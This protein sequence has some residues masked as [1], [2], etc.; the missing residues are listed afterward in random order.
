MRFISTKSSV[1][2]FFGTDDFFK[3]FKKREIKWTKKVKHS[4]AVKENC[5]VIDVDD[6]RKWY[7]YIGINFGIPKIT[8]YLPKGK[9]GALLVKTSTSDV[10]GSLLIDKVFF[11]E[12][13]TGN[14][15]FIIAQ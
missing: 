2:D 9:Y 12:T 6:T 7:E 11:T 14:I 8:V 1:S 15:N 3:T 10:T 13:D 5:L 4:V